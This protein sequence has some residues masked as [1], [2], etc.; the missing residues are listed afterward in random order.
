MKDIVSSEIILRKIYLIRG[1]KVMLDHDLAE[2]Y[3][4]ETKRLK[5]QV[6]RNRRRFP[7]DFMFHLTTDEFQILRS[8]SATSRWGGTRYPPMAFSEQGVAMLS[9]IL[10]SDVAI[11]V[12]IKIMRTFTQLRRVFLSDD[13]I[14]EKI[15]NL[16]NF[17]KLKFKETDTDIQAIISVLNMI[18]NPEFKP[19]SNEQIGFKIDN[20]K[21]K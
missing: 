2:L 1:I 7:H 10:N 19:D 16:E 13:D 17:M 12:N 5:E 3:G 4:V 8:Q 11:D 6:K 18:M 9:S 21:N 14:R 15:N 20:G